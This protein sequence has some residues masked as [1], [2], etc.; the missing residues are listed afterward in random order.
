MLLGS[1]YAFKKIKKKSAAFIV[2]ELGKFELGH[3]YYSDIYTLTSLIL[4]IT[5]RS[6]LLW[7]M[8]LPS[9][10]VC[11]KHGKWLMMS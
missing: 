6:V 2:I 1:V 11:V 7:K 10:R 9:S 8:C 5:Y 3:I 4:I